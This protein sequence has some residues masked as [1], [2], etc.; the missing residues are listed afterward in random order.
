MF[1]YAQISEAIFLIL[2]PQVFAIIVVGT[3]MGLLVGSLP[4]LSGTMA[5]AIALPITF[6]IS[7]WFGIPLILS[8]YKSSQWAGAVGSILINTPGNAA[9]AAM[10]LDGYP[11][12]KQGHGQR[13]LEASLKSGWAADVLSDIITILVCQPLAS[14]ALFFRPPEFTLIIVIAFMMIATMG[15]G[16]AIKTLVAA[17]LGLFVST[18][19]Q[20]PLLG[21]PRLNFNISD[22]YS[23]FNLV[24]LLIGVFA[25][26]EI[27]IQ[28]TDKI[29]V[30]QQASR[31]SQEVLSERD[32]GFAPEKFEHFKFWEIKNYF[33]AWLRSSLIG[34]WIGVLP[35]I[36]SGV[37]PWIAYGVSKARSKHPEEYGKGSL[38]GLISAQAACNAV[39]GANLVPL[40][41]LGIP[42]DT[43]AAIL[44]GALMVHG[45][46]PG[47]MFF[48]SD[49]ISVYAIFV[50]LLI[51]DAVYYFAGKLFVRGVSKISAFDHSILLP[52]V[53]MFCVLGTYAINTSLFDVYV[54]LAFGVVG[55]VMKKNDYSTPAFVIAYVLGYLFEMNLRQTF[56]LSDG[57][58]WIFLKDPMCAFLFAMNLA[59]LV[60]FVKKRLAPSANLKQ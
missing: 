15:S 13:A 51:C 33:W 29:S 31:S 8:I 30:S 17:G 6:Y 9:N 2:T 12:R 22:L 26:S 28:I 14:V 60:Y 54:M 21:T 50:T 34:T 3:L 59:V 43:T 19:G 25:M 16:S 40:I 56:R 11:L 48:K 23:G 39:G 41:S 24:P 49:P 47:P 20:D 55:Y 45:I 10:L 44:L 42:G 5:I 58:I 37:S 18:V 46:Q 4:G 52:F 38:E 7:P 57:H 35:G 32:G 36:G 53:L 27:F 1:M